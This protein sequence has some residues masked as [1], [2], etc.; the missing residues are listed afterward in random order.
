[1]KDAPATRVR[2][3][4][5]SPPNLDSV[6]KHLPANAAHSSSLICNMKELRVEARGEGMF[7]VK[8]DQAADTG[9]TLIG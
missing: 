9:V 7:A 3:Y 4:N 8:Q 5:Q 6:Q 1:M 2:S